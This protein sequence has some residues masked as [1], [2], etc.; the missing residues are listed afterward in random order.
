MVGIVGCTVTG[1]GVGAAVNGAGALEG[2][3]PEHRNEV[4]EDT[5]NLVSTQSSF[6]AHCTLH[7]PVP[8][9]MMVFPLQAS[10]PLHITL[11]SVALDPSIR[12]FPE[13]TLS[14]THFTLHLSPALQ[15]TLAS[16][17]LS[18]PVHCN[19]HVCPIKAFPVGHEHAP[20]HL[21][22]REWT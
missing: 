20:L 19:V 12:A 5:A 8:H 11:T 15:F 4:A 21:T 10:D 3:C 1:T 22:A 16:L 14:P 7:A 18:D 6:L 13:H 2:H 17:Q 9:V